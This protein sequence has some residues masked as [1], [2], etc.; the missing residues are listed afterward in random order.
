[1]GII[2]FNISEQLL[3]QSLAIPDDAE[4]IKIFNHDRTPSEFVFYVRS[5]KF[6]LTPEG[7]LPLEVSP[8][9]TTNYEN[10]PETWLKI[11]FNI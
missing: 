2:C 1:M 9:I 5:D 3:R 6:P 8:T 10:R 4:I 7:A 11:D